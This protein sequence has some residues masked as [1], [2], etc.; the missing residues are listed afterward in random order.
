MED[1]SARELER[2]LKDSK[3]AKWFC[4]FNLTESTLDY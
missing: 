2:Y 1:M 3:A 4:E